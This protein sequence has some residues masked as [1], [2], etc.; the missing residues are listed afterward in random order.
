[1]NLDLVMAMRRC[2]SAIA[3]LC[4]LAISLGCSE[5]TERQSNTGAI[6]HKGNGA[7]PES[8]DPHIITG[9]PEFNIAWALFE[10]L[11]ALAPR[12]LEPVP[13]AAKS[14]E[15]SED[16][17]IYRFTIRSD[18]RWS[19]GDPLTATDFVFAWQ[20][21]LSPGLGGAY[22][23][24][25]H[26]IENARDYNEGRI[27]DFSQVGVH[28]EGDNLLVVRLVRPTPHFL[29]MLSLPCYMPLH[30][31]T[32][33]RFGTIDDRNAEW[34]RAGNLVSNGLFQ[35]THW[36]PNRALKVRR[37]PHYWDANSVRLDGVDFHP[38]QSVQT[39]ER[40][41]RTGKLHLTNTLATNKI[42]V[43]QRENPDL[44][45]IDPQFGTYFYRFNTT[46]PPLDDRRVRR[47]LAMSINREEIVKYVTRGG[48]KIAESLV[49]PG[50][51]YRCDARIPYDVERARALLA[52]AGYPDGKGF[53][54]MTV[55]YNTSEDH[56]IIAEAVQ[57]MWR[58]NLGIDITLVNQ[59]WKVY[60]N[61]V[62]Q[63]DYEIARGSW[64]GD[65]IDPSSFLNLFTSYSAHNR[66]GYSNPEYDALIEKAVHTL[67]RDSRFE[68]LQEAE[69]LLL[70]DAPIA[71]IYFYAIVH[72]KVPELKGLE[73]NLL[74]YFVYKNMYFDQ[75]EKPD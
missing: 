66:A 16:G 29:F 49:P 11:T 39:E 47:A 12:T 62:E 34:T 37:N 61:T 36:Q 30:G 72:L 67:D 19:N 3:V 26:C 6:L 28:A 73:P 46:R 23:E 51:G 31:P 74:D 43:Y 35:L 10:G 55:L 33:L 68:V 59:D 27:N 64:I 15:V 71:P 42:E 2:A 65:Y 20:R 63:L 17:L 5:S 70:E 56:R 38:I 18:A 40:A 75:T 41:F 22:A 24:F 14:W 45:H 8:L 53:P 25:L 48:Q 69:H 44:L 7:E 13:G 58:T 54:T 9:Q 57:H 4:M 52:E 21:M 32:V 1:M 50:S 60:L